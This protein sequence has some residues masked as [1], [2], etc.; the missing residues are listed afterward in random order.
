[1]SRR[2]QADT[3]PSSV[4]AIMRSRSFQRGVAEVRAGLLPDFDRFDDWDY[5]R[6]RQWAT[7]APGDMP[8]KIG[9]RLNPNAVLLFHQSEIP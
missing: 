2:D 4:E 3:V 5:E 7:A 9:K 6:G 1:M 8:V